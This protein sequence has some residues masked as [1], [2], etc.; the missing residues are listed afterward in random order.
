MR[1]EFE[2]SRQG[3]QRNK[4]WAETRL[5]LSDG[6]FDFLRETH[7]GA[8]NKM[9]LPGIS[10]APPQIHSSCMLRI[11]CSRGSIKIRQVDHIW[12]VE[13]PFVTSPGLLPSRPP[14]RIY[15]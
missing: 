6:A 8:T 5:C 1:D 7:V 3:T 11:L 10:V 14:I 4:E 9:A 12:I 2:P 15:W 13:S